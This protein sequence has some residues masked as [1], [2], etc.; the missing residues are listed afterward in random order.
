M[1]AN[2]TAS[3]ASR[4]CTACGLCCNG[5]LFHTVRLQP[6]DSAKELTALGMKLKHKSKGT[7]IHQPCP[8]L[9]EL[10]CTIYQHR[11]ERCR[12]FECQQLTRLAA[13]ETTEEAVLEA[14]HDVQRRVAH[15]ETL[16][17]QAGKTDP[18]R[19]LSKRCDK[20]LADPLP[21]TQGLRVALADAMWELNDLLNRDFRLAPVGWPGASIQEEQPAHDG[22]S[23]A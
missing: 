15:L 21:A 5:V 6:K 4:L 19:P 22:G 1:S 20:I 9:R 2:A 13:G 3:A 12:L 11:P 7:S 17:R 23:E 10:Q 18:K 14:I 8:A 16:M